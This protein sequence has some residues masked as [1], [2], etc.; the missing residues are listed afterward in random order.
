MERDFQ[1]KKALDRFLEFLGFEIVEEEAEQREPVIVLDEKSYK[2]NVHN[3]CFFDKKLKSNNL[4]QGHDKMAVINKKI[5]VCDTKVF[6]CKLSSFEDVRKVADYLKD[7]NSVVVNLND[8]DIEQAERALNYLSGV[9]FAIA[10]RG[11]RVGTGVFIF[12][13]ASVF[14]DNTDKDSEITGTKMFK[15]KLFSKTESA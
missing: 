12:T 11:S 2:H 15:V 8:L 3:V 5:E 10:G 13:P 7:N 1:K 14:I 6:N 4:E 9:I